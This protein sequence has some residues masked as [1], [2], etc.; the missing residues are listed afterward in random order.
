V[1]TKNLQI[2]FLNKWRNKNIYGE[3]NPL[4]P[5]A[6]PFEY[7][8]AI[9]MMAQ[10]LAWFEGTGLPE[11][12]LKIAPVIKKYR[13]IQKD[14]HAGIVY[15]IGNEPSGFGW[16]GFQSVLNENSGYLLIFRE[17][18]EY[19]QMKIKTFLPADSRIKLVPMLGDG[20]S[21]EQTVGSGQ[22]LEVFLPH[23][24]SYALYR[25]ETNMN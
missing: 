18:N 7:Q 6:I 9:T 13:E 3:D 14:I 24:F 16:T 25:Y 5:Y 4:A 17:K 21:Q 11:E 1:P 19:S 20:K 2:E 8:F 15:P 12:A 10:P 22:E 23:E